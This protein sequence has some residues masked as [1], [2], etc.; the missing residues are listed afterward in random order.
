MAKPVIKLL[1][2]GTGTFAEEIADVAF[3][4]PGI[5]PAGFVENIDRQK[6]KE[7]LNDL[8]VYWVDEL[9]HLAKTHQ[10]VCGLGTTHRDRYVEQAA[11]YNIPFA[12]LVHP[13][14]RISS[15]SS[16]GEGTFVSA[17]AII[18][19][20]TCLGIH[21]NVNRG[22]LIGHHTNI[23]SFVTVGPGA[24]IAGNCR[25]DR[26]TYIGMGALVLD[27]ISIGAHSVIGAGAVV[28]HNVP[29]NVQ[30]VGIPARIVKENIE[31]K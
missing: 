4:I 13:S 5:E 22:A 24:N 7:K 3:E 20:Y 18:A 23:D 14:A 30:V 17:G 31:G 28:T 29:N 11:Q 6:C 19:A 16:L 8:P 9:E 1:V 21:V 27:H 2:L 12:T 26:C 10:A 25:I 15:K